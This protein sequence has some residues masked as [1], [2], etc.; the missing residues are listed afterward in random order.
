MD[1]QPHEP[2]GISLLPYER[3]VS[4]G[5]VTKGALSRFLPGSLI[6]L[7]WLTTVALDLS[8]SDQVLASTG[9]LLGLAGAL[10]LGF[11]LGLAGL[12]RWLFPDA[13]VSGRKSFVAGLLS[14][15]AAFIGATL[16]GGLSGLEIPFVMALV[17]AL[18]ALGMFFAWLS[19]TPEHMRGAEFEDL[20]GPSSG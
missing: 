1:L 13:K 4:L 9:G 7:G 14:P 17:G 10:T 8:V 19:P 18:M 6:G 15:V 11:G 5:E 2:E 3:G 16:S 20:A 12:R